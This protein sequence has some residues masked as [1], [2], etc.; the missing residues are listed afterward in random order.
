VVVGSETCDVYFRDIKE[1]IQ[2][3]LNN[4]TLAEH[5]FF[6]PE[7]HYTDE[8]RTTRMYHDMYTSKWWWATQ[9]A[10]E[11]ESPGATIV[12]VIISTDK[13]QLTLFRNKS[14]YPVYLTI[15]NIPK[16]I[17]RKPS[18]QAYILLG[19]L[20]TTHLETVTNKTAR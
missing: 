1:C 5:M 12:P 7:K 20:P 14:A 8:S 3:L 10:V 9:R 4:P 18:A 17:R 2:A 19:Y 16:E 13:T 6:V 15:G 11:K